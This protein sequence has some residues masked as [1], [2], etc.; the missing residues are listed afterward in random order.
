MT[1]HPLKFTRF[2]EAEHLHRLCGKGEQVQVATGE[3]A[4]CKDTQH[5]TELGMHQVSL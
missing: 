4:S 2:H 1:Q 3:A 5:G